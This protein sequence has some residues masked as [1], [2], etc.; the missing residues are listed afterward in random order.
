MARGLSARNQAIQ[1]HFSQA[2]TVAARTRRRQQS[3]SRMLPFLLITHHCLVA[4]VTASR[5]SLA[6]LQ[7]ALLPLLHQVKEAALRLEEV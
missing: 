3:L 6:T 2:H 7:P 4:R 5:S 1:P